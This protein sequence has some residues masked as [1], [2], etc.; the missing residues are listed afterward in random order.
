MLKHRRGQQFFLAVVPEQA[1]QRVIAIQQAA[2]GRCEVHA[3]LERLEQLGETH[4]T[5]ALLGDVLRHDTYAHDFAVVHDGMEYAIEEPQ[6]RFVPEL[7][8]QNARPVP[9]LQEARHGLLG[10]GAG[11]FRQ[12]FF[13]VLAHDLSERSLQQVGARPVHGVD[14][15]LQGN[16]DDGRVEAVDQFT[17]TAL[18]VAD[19]FQQLAQLLFAGRRLLAFLH[20]AHHAAQLRH[21]VPL[22]GRVNRKQYHQQQRAAGQHL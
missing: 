5:L 10:L 22:R 21:L 7:Y 8:P 12:E 16:S 20:A 3:L 15:A 11:R 6:L 9:L 4:F 19:D 17:V 2:V 1:D 13:Q 18:R 14:R